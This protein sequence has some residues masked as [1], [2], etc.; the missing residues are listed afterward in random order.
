MGTPTVIR[1]HNNGFGFFAL[2]ISMSADDYK[3]QV[4]EEADD[5]ILTLKVSEHYSTQEGANERFYRWYD[6]LGRKERV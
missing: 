2:V 3:F 1:H 6:A 4:Y 5:G